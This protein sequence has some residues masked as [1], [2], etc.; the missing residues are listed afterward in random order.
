[1]TANVRSKMH[2]IRKTITTNSVR[3][4]PGKKLYDLNASDCS[5]SICTAGR[6]L[7]LINTELKDGQELFNTLL[8]ANVVAASIVNTGYFNLQVGRP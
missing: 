8:S 4:S 3:S 1:M 7:G 5:S 2:I 6:A